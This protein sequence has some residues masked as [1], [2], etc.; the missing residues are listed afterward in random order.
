MPNRK[1][2]LEV[3]DFSIR[4]RPSAVYPCFCSNGLLMTGPTNIVSSS[5]L[6]S[7][8]PPNRTQSLLSSTASSSIVPFACRDPSG[9]DDRGIPGAVPPPLL[10]NYGAAN[11][12]AYNVDIAVR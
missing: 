10:A 2:T 11:E 4:S 3:Q 7:V 6:S 5:S 8:P 12:M 1:V 9:D